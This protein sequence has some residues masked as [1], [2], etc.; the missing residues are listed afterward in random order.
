MTTQEIKDLVA[1]KIAGQGNQV[2]LAG[3]LPEILTALVEQLES[4]KNIGITELRAEEMQATAVEITEE[5]YNEIFLSTIVMDGEVALVRTHGADWFKGVIQTSATGALDYGCCFAQATLPFGV[6]APKPLEVFE[7]TV[8][9]A[10]LDEDGKYY[11]VRV[12]H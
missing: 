6:E 8:I 1:S 5:R 12:E 7:G 4:L 11:L 9:Y 10:G 3:A 2:D